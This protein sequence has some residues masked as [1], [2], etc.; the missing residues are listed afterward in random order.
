MELGGKA[1]DAVLASLVA[2]LELRP[3]NVEAVD[4]AVSRTRAFILADTE[5]SESL[6]GTDDS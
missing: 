1:V 6:V 5:A 3:V 4:M 2:D